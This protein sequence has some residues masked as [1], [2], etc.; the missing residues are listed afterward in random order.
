M[1]KLGKWDINNDPECVF[2]K[3]SPETSA[4]LFWDC[5][6]TTQLWLRVFRW[7]QVPIPTNVHLQQWFFRATK[8][9]SK[10]AKLLKQVCTD[11]LYSFW[12]ERST[13]IFDKMQRAPEELVKEMACIFIVRATGDLRSYLLG[14]VF[15]FNFFDESLLVL[16]TVIVVGLVWSS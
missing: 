6:F 7:L 11:T 13:R 9:N 8:G 5:F 14:L 15:S 4:H 10:R 1:D 16:L 2:C 3:T 12:T